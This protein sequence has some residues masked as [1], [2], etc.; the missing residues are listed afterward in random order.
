MSSPEMLQEVLDASELAREKKSG[1]AKAA[2]LRILVTVA[3][4]MIWFWTQSL[5][6]AR[7]SPTDGIGDR[8]ED[9]AHALI[10]GKELLAYQG[11]TGASSTSARSAAMCRSRAV[12]PALVAANHVW[13]LR[14]WPFF[15]TEA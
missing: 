7:I 1:A 2:A 10:I 6:G 8:F 12:R 13:P 3:A 11:A 5:L 15:L 4:L 9:V 14:P